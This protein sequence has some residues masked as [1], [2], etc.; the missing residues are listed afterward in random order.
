MDSATS[1]SK[2]CAI[3]RSVHIQRDGLVRVGTGALLLLREGPGTGTG[4]SG[5]VDAPK[6]VSAGAFTRTE[7]A[8]ISRPGPL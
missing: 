1:G 6:D 7:A 3:I 8:R 2:G 5:S 4:R